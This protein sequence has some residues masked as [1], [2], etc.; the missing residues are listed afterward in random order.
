MKKFFKILRKIIKILLRI[1]LWS[2]LLLISIVIFLNNRP[3][4]IYDNYKI[5][6]DTTK[7]IENWKEFYFNI[8]NF[9][10]LEILIDMVENWNLYWSAAYDFNINSI[11]FYDVAYYKNGQ[12]QHIIKIFSH[13]PEDSWVT[14]LYF[15]KDWSIKWK[16][17]YLYNENGDIIEN[18]YFISYHN[19]WQIKEEWNY[20]NWEKIWTRTGY[21]ENWK[22]ESVCDYTY[23]MDEECVNYDINN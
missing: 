19:N 3:F 2:L 15:N 16:W 13:N 20:D 21:Y 4:K 8:K 22:I 23:W 9:K 7:K 18:W 1:I 17:N 11:E 12:I 10:N 5:T 14:L 6:F